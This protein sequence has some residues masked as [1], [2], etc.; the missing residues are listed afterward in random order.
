MHPRCRRRCGRDPE[1]PAVRYLLCV[2][3][4]IGL[5][6][7]AVALVTS[8]V[9]AVAQV[10]TCA[11]GG[12]YVIANQC[13]DGMGLDI[14]KLIGGIVLLLVGVGVF[15]ARGRPGGAG[16]AVNPASGEPLSAVPRAGRSAGLAVAAWGM[17][18]IASRGDLV[19]ANGDNAPPTATGRSQ[20]RS[21]SCSARW[22][23][24]CW[25]A[26]RHGG[27]LPHHTAVRSSA[28]AAARSWARRRRGEPG[29]PRAPGA[30]DRAGS[31]GP[32]AGRP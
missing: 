20:P 5:A 23:P 10:G 9:F 28:W 12:P 25:R 30:G 27:R 19:P 2:V 17:L 6:V 15:G 1:V 7:T 16:S 18:W 22:A 13:P 26:G 3:I 11:S 8:G 4:G 14:M 21:P 31:S 29:R 24:C 32:R